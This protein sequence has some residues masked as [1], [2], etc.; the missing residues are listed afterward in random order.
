MRGAR[1]ISVAA[2]NDV[3]EQYC[4]DCHNDQMLTGNLSLDKFD[5]AHA[6]AD[7]HIAEK[8]I[9]KLRAEM[10][11]LPGSPRPGGDTL[12]ALAETM[13]QI[14]DKG[15][16]PNPGSR[17]FQRLNRPEYEHVIRDLLG[18]EVN[19]GDWLPLDTKSANFDNI[20]DVLTMW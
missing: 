11:P 3:V 7:A 8:M 16:R 10:M 2:L 17:P 6:D 20:A 18:L 5:V 13:E 4:K 15:S 14:I 1:G 12:T 9:R 19:A